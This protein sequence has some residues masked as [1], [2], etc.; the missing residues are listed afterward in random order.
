MAAPAKTGR[1]NQRNRTRK[2]L[3]QAAARLMAAGRKPDL[4]EIAA[5]AQVSRAT[6][7]RYFPGVEALLLE[8]ALDVATPEPEVLF[9]GA[10]GEGP[11]A[12]VERVNQALHQ[13][14]AANEGPLR[15]MLINA[16]ERSLR[17]SD[18]DTPAR[19]N[20]R[21]PLIQAA[22]APA[23]DQFDP[24][25]LAR[26]EAALALIVGTEAMVVFKDV[27]RVDDAEAQAVKSWAIEA[28]VAAARR[29]DA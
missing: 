1:P 10:E 6:A 18:A 8:A 19:Q 13:M 9:R 20:R 7:Y 26:L 12:R 21:T 27:L 25:A 4:E 2:D 15:M 22:L 29:K 28:L 11:E 3:L 17:E 24:T 16:L 23:R 5:E 14:M